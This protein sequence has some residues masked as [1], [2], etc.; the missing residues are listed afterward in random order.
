M[1]AFQRLPDFDAVTTCTRE[2]G[3][4]DHRWILARHELL[5]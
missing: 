1:R 4:S 3:R 5:D 2:V